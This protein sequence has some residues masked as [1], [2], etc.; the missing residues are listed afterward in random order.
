MTSIAA[1]IRRHRLARKHRREQAAIDAATLATAA[2]A[3]EAELYHRPHPDDLNVRRTLGMIEAVAAFDHCVST[4]DVLDDY[5]D[6]V[7]R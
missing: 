2:R 4:E 3:V 6:G 5:L 1:F 7:L